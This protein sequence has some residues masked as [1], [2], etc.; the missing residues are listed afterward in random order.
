[1]KM[2]VLRT[3]VSK[4]FH[5]LLRDPRTL[6]I[7]L[8]MPMVLLLL[9]GFAIS[10]DVND[11]RVAVVASNHTDRTRQVVERLRT[12][13]Y[14]TFVGLTD[15]QDIDR[16]LRTSQ[17][18]AVV[19]LEERNGSLRSQIVTDG[20]N[21][22]L[23]Q[24]S[25]GY[26]TQLIAGPGQ[27]API[28]SHVLYN[29]QLRS[30]YNFVPGILGLI[31]LL[32]CSIMTSVSIVSERQSGTMDL[33]MVSPVRPRTVILGKLVPYFLLSCMILVLMLTLS[34][35]VL[36][37][38]FSAKVVD[39]VLIS[40]LYVAL[41]LSVGLLVSTLVKTE[42]AA[43]IVSAIGFMIPV[44]MLSGM[45]FPIDNMPKVLQWFSCVV[46]ARWYIS[47]MRKLM[48]QQLPVEHVAVEI[49]VLAAMTVLL[50]LLAVKK[51][52]KR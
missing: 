33:M 5:K 44:I 9:F 38:P 30:S 14:F 41:A 51:F 28:V 19:M 27:P 32:I 23:A 50:L 37:I 10:T 39:V 1:M 25:Q 11:V 26:I 24:A 34:Y 35:T 12:N 43:L 31:F 21:T 49:S 47:A 2:S 46:P 18:D 6:L 42:V 20:S 52:K 3:I 4:E 22:T 36:G 29:P 17:A 8:V 15:Y 45:I 7:V 13:P 40:I 16:V 48:I